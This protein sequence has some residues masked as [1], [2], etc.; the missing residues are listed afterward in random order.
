MVTNFWALASTRPHHVARSLA[1][2]LNAYLT[3]ARLQFSH[4]MAGLPL[5]PCP[6]Q[7]VR[8]LLHLESWSLIMC[9]ANLYFSFLARTP[10]LLAIVLGNKSIIFTLSLSLN[11][12]M[13]RNMA[14][15]VFCIFR[16]CFL[17]VAHDCAPYKSTGITALSRI[18]MFVFSCI[19]LLNM[20]LAAQNAFYELVWF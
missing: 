10:T 17:A 19:L 18:L 5:D 11:R 8:V 14:F 7:V 20:Y 6:V 2:S 15:C 3:K 4:H 13:L 1:S 16:V 12:R 9:P